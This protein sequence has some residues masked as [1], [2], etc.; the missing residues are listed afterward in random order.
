MDTGLLAAC[1]RAPWDLHPRNIFADHCEDNGD[2]T[3]AARL[4]DPLDFSIFLWTLGRIGPWESVVRAG[5]PMTFRAPSHDSLG[6]RPGWF[7]PDNTKLGWSGRSGMIYWQLPS[8]NTVIRWRRER[9]RAFW[10]ISFMRPGTT[11]WRRIIINWEVAQAILEET[12]HRTPR[13]WWF[14]YAYWPAFIGTPPKDLPPMHTSHMQW[15][16]SD[17]Y[18]VDQIH[19]EDN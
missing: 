2:A 5:A 7:V 15:S 8:K 16:T 18:K 11:Q 9:L 4:R 3:L 19:R 12:F 10:S 1:R 17:L 6:V 13:G 14:Q